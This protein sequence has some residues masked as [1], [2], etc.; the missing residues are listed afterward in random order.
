MA[1][2]AFPVPD[3]SVP[4]L[5]HRH[6]RLRRQE[7]GAI[8]RL[9]DGD[10]DGVISP[11]EAESALASLAG[12]VPHGPAGEL[13]TL[14]V[15]R[16]GIDAA[17][18]MAWA[19][20]QAP[21][22]L[23]LT[24]RELFDLIDADGSGC[25]CCEELAVLLGSLDPS[26]DESD[27][28]ALMARHDLDLNG[29]LTYDEF[30][31]LVLDEEDLAIS[32]ADLRRLRKSLLQYRQASRE[33]R[34][35]V[36]E[37]DCDLG[38][39]IRGAGD[40]IDLLRQA[41]DR[42]RALRSLAAGL[43]E[44]FRA[45]A[46]PPGHRDRGPTPAVEA[47]PH[48]RHI[49]TIAAVIEDV[50]DLVATSLRRG[51][52]P[53]V[54]A[55]DHSTAAGTIAGLRR[56][57]PEARIGVVWIDAHADLHSPY[58]TP[59]GN[60]HG[61]PVAIATGHDNRHHAINEPDAFTLSLWEH[62]KALTGTGEAAIRLRDVVYVSLR[63]AEPAEEATIRA[64][65]IAVVETAEVRRDGPE[66]AA[67]RCLAHLADC[68]RLYVSFDVD[69]IDAALCKGTGTPAPGGILPEEA[70]R[71]HR[72]LLRDPRVCC[73]EICEINPHLD[74]L[75]S[76]GDISLGVYATVME[77]LHRRLVGCEAGPISV[78]PAPR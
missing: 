23:E 58:T 51:L 77:E 41:A 59:S 64:H 17:T 26:L 6:E 35:A 20:R 48:A 65:G 76:I 43:T 8:F 32:L 22:D 16:D 13:R 15:E 10:G 68:D 38:A 74:T 55:G 25:L 19:L 45:R 7:L 11:A 37:V 73:W 30:L 54:L 9:F 47:T 42:H 52:F 70:Q 60:M 34:I 1:A 72:T 27:L 36:L 50:A 12:V 61:M 2:D 49:A 78:P 46:R 66:K 56:A 28:A 39:G 71:F 18:F 75:N 31:R 67:A 24:L 40:G 62:C 5:L 53:V 4:G 14:A 3:R 69:S 57:L 33:S 44:E 29:R 63:D 21:F